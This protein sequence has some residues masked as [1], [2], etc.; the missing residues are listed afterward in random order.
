VEV[1][2]ID[3]VTSTWNF[4]SDRE[5]ELLFLGLENAPEMARLEDAIRA[6]F[7]QQ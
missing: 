7:T 6:N 2:D 5:V 4:T 1:A 3:Y